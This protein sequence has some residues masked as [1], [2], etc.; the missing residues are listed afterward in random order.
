MIANRTS[1]LVG[2]M[3]AMAA[4]LIARWYFDNPQEAVHFLNNPLF[5]LADSPIF[6]I[7]WATLA[8]IGLA[9]LNER[10]A[11]LFSPGSWI[12]S[13]SVASLVIAVAPFHLSSGLLFGI[14]LIAVSAAWSLFATPNSAK[15]LAT[16]NGVRGIFFVSGMA[17]LIYQ[18]AWQKKLISLLGADGQSVTVIVAVFLGGLGVGALIGDKV[19]PSLGSRRGIVAFCVIE[20]IAGLFGAVS[21]YWL[22]WIGGFASGSFSSAVLIAAAAAAIGLPTVLMGMTLPILVETLKSSST[23]LHENAGKLYAVNALG[24]AVASLLAAT[25]LFQFTGLI[26]ATWVAATL[27]ALTASLVFVAARHWNRQQEPKAIPANGSSPGSPLQLSLSWQKASLLAGLT[28]FI[29]I[30][31]EVMLLRMMSWSSGGAPWTFG[32]GVGTFLL[33]LGFGS[34]RLSRLETSSLLVEGSGIWSLTALI[35][36]LL[37][38]FAALL[39]GITTPTAGVLFLAITLGLIG[40]LGGSSLPLIAGQIRP[41][42]RGNSHFGTVYSVN[43]VGS[44]AGAVITG[45]ILFDIFTTAQCIAISAALSLLTSAIFTWLAKDNQSMPLR[46]HLVLA[47]L[48]LLTLPLHGLLYARWLEWQNQGTL[49]AVTFSKTV[50]TRAGIIAVKPDE[51]GDIIIGGGVYDGRFNVDPLQTSN[52]IFRPYIAMALLPEPNKILEIGLS[53]GSWAKAILSF[54]SVREFRSIEINPG[55]L[56]LIAENEMV[57]EILTDPRASYTVADGRKWLQANKEQWQMIVMNTTFYW[58]DGATLLHSKE[59]MELVRNRLTPNGI[60][61]LNTTGLQAIG[62]TALSVFPEVYQLSNCII[63]ING[64]LAAPD[65]NVLGKRLA[66]SSLFAKHGLDEAKSIKWVSQKLP[67]ALDP[68]HYSNCSILT[69]DAMAG[70]WGKWRC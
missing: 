43:I 64:H 52:L 57:S 39:G 41:N 49:R 62:A 31:Q 14:I 60:L 55:Y 16:P 18:V 66:Q 47:S 17:A 12:P 21:M 1:R 67:V 70:E 48:V 50:E 42:K 13:F 6:P 22:E 2:S 32:V 19:G 27:N 10:V 34:L 3:L 58:R 46:R 45:Y 51:G 24:S 8:L 68:D 5:S 44:V 30:G 26:G 11:Q 59:L 15:P 38:A 35:T 4:L 20:V 54:P 63:A 53:S 33:G 56:R 25:L 7:I 28:G 37:P 36:L 65:A 23:F 29:T 69:D 61:L 9:I 40:F